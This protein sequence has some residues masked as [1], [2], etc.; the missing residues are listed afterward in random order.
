MSNVPIHEPRVSEDSHYASTVSDG[1][2]GRKSTDSHHLRRRAAKEQQLDQVERAPAPNPSG[3]SRTLQQYQLVPLSA[4]WMQPVLGTS[5]QGPS[6]VDIHLEA[7]QT[8]VLL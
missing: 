3:Q 1:T 2:S 6:S 7:L 4:D 5:Y 8:F